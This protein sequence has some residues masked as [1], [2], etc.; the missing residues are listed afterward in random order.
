MSPKICGYCQ[1]PIDDNLYQYVYFSETKQHLPVHNAHL[2]WSKGINKG[3]PYN[4]G[5][6]E[7]SKKG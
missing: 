7:N 3:T 4:G 2:E 5:K 1:E 6:H